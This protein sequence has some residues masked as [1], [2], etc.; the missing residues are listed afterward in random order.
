[1]LSIQYYLSL[2]ADDIEI[3][4]SAATIEEAQAALQSYLSAIEE[5]AVLWRLT[6]SIGKCAAMVF[7]RRRIQQNPLLLNL[8]GSPIPVVD[9]F[10]FLGVIFDSKLLW[11][12]HI[13]Y[14]NNRMRSQAGLLKILSQG[15]TTL[16][17]LHLV[18]VFK[19]LMRSRLDYGAIVLNGMPNARIR[20]LEA[21]QNRLLRIIL[22][23]FPS[24]PLALLHLESGIEPVRSRWNW[25]ATRYLI[26]L[27]SKPWNPAHESIK[28]AT[29]SSIVWLPRSTPAVI[30]VIRD[31]RLLDRH[32]FSGRRL[33]C[34]RVPKFPPW[35][36]I[37][38]GIKLF[39]IKKS[40]AALDPRR[41][42]VQFAEMTSDEP[43][44]HASIFTDGS[45][46]KSSATVACAIF[47][48]KEGIKQSWSLRK[49]TSV[50]SS[51]VI[52]ILKGLQ[53]LSNFEY[54]EV[55]I[56]SDSKSAIEAIKGRKFDSSPYILAV[57]EEVL[58][59][60]AAGTGVNLAWIPSH[61]GI[62]GNE[63]ADELAAAG[64]TQPTQG[65][66]ANTLSTSERIAA[67]SGKRISE[68]LIKSKLSSTN[69]AVTSRSSFGPLPW[70]LHRNRKIQIALLR[71]RSGHNRLNHF[72]SRFDPDT[73]DSCPN[74]CPD[75][76]DAHHVLFICQQYD[77]ERTHLTEFFH[78]NHLRFDLPSILGLNNNIPKGT[79]S[80]IQNL[81]IAFLVE[82]GLIG[83]V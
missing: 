80:A 31:M 44:L 12:K 50:F 17:L 14:A 1:M 19:A 53:I 60:R 77:A 24:V 52:A 59:L 66:M 56:F 5:W 49:D 68:L 39:P 33:Q 40:A 72:V 32:V 28:S 64:R 2:Y 36:V 57:L 34:S 65:A 10:K 61:C 27:D 6:F 47:F 11:T 22:G 74:G 81:L 79:Q 13:D 21:T 67:R 38:I 41:T 70:H 26:N 62:P 63:I 43:A 46:D 9:H 69:L 82:S 45:L 35:S 71:L 25:L 55:T 4:A 18:R 29:S 75:Q 73:P 15:K 54:E 3:H 76:E 58:V 7:S 51:E 37:D 78:N 23:C 8:I 16:G 48:P 30:S 42:A 83:R 20:P